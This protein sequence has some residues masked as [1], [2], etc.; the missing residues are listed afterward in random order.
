MNGLATPS[1]ILVID[2]ALR[3]AGVAVIDGDDLRAARTGTPESGL[4]D[5]LAVWVD[6]CLAEAGLRAI[7]LDAIA[8][9]IGP[10]SFTGLRAALALAQGIGSAAG[11][12]VHGVAMGDA[13]AAVLPGLRRPL[14]IATT[15]RRGR[16]FLERGGIVAGF[17]DDA[18]PAP[19]EPVALAGD[20]AGAVAA[21]LAARGY[22][23]MLTDAR[24]CPVVAIAAALRLRQQAGLPP[25]PAVPAYVDPPEAKLPA[26]GLRPP[27]GSAPAR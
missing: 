12:P 3:R 2:A 5:L 7:E 15:A 1:R 24:Y 16:V 23:V 26:G 20:K 19:D 9:T 10:G 17:D 25:R 4:A 8:V 14:W 22:D 27:P 21:T 18:V 13:F 6:E 11:V